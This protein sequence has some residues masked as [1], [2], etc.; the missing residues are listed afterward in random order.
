M[1]F[2]PMEQQRFQL[3]LFTSFFVHL[4]VII[5]LSLSVK[6]ALPKNAVSSL[7]VAYQII[8]DKKENKENSRDDF[9]GYQ[10]TREPLIAKEPLT[11]GNLLAVKNENPFRNEGVS[12]SRVIPDKKQKTEINIDEENREIFVPSVIVE[13]MGGPKYFNYK[14]HIRRKIK[15]KAYGHIE[16]PKFNSG[17]VYL[18]F[19]LLAD[20][21]LRQIRIVEDK[22]E[23]NE[24]LRGIG[25][26]SVQ[27]ANP[28][29][30]FPKD[31]NYPEL[32]FSVPI[33]FRVNK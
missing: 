30:P 16:D 11:A 29:P 8:E 26:K 28:F 33:S 31:L 22:T 24:Y 20:G 1:T 7:E 12:A 18:T 19:V 32:T 14:E 15:E 6:E 25:L 4:L 5:G 27:E 10:K 9:R 13:K 3:A 17:E 23:A 2:F 21:S